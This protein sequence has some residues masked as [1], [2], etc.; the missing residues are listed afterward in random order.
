MKFRCVCWIIGTLLALLFA[1]PDSRA[2]AEQSV[3]DTAISYA[4]RPVL[5]ANPPCVQV[6][7]EFQIPA[8]QK[9]IVLRMP[10]WSPGDYHRQNHGKYVLGLTADSVAD[11]IKAETVTRVDENTWEIV[12]N[13]EG[14]GAGKQRIRYRLSQT[15]PG[16]FSENVQ[17]QAHQVFMNGPA[18]YLYLEGRKESPARVELTLPQGWKVE[19]ALLPPPEINAGKAR[20]DIVIT[21]GTEAETTAL[22]RP[23]QAWRGEGPLLLT[24]PDYDTLADSPLVL[25]DHLRTRDFRVA[26]ILH[27]VVYF[28]DTASLKNA[29]DYTQML[30]EIVTAEVAIMGGPPY[31]KYEFLFDVGG[32]GGGLEHLNCARLPLWPAE[33]PARFAPFTAHELFHAWNVKRIRPAVLGPF[34]YVHPPR[35]HNLW[36]AEGVTQ[37][38]AILATR[39]AGLISEKEFVAHWLRAIH[40]LQQNPAR[41]SVTA[42]E[43]SWHVWE[44]GNSEG[45]GGLSY[46]DKGELIGLCLDLKIRHVTANRRSLDDVM[47]L[48][49]QRHNF[50]QPGYGEEELRAVVSEVADEDLGAFYD[51]LARSTREM[52]FEECLGYAGLDREGSP[53]AA[54]TPDETALREEWARTN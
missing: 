17:V 3:S 20:A 11:E 4:L 54:A 33:E 44:S 37:Y 15:P 48:L 42:E 39:R 28:G 6:T 2:L 26:G 16:F 18:T 30:Q 23:T 19:T 27:R 36:F 9:K 51:A 14:R 10:A 21:E 41:H 53:L 38:Y 29:D 8:T 46:Y 22:A 35:T 24:A 47:R 12:T 45:Y 1:L 49:M 32:R 40:A 34:D 13:P 25:S 50:P 31:N 43:A 7:M 52:P 5:D